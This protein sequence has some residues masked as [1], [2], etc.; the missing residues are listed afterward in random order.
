MKRTI[1]LVFIGC[2]TINNLLAQIVVDNNDQPTILQ[3]FVDM[4]THPRNDLAFGSELFYGCP[5][6][7]ISQAM[8]NCNGY[9]GGYGMFDNTQGNLFRNK[10]VEEGEGSF[11][12]HVEHIREGY[13]NFG[14]WPSF[15]SIFHQQMWIDWIRRAHEGGL[16]IMVAL[17]THSHCMA[18][19]AETKGPYDDKTV[20]DNSI[21]GIRDLVKN[22]DFMEIALS[23][24]DVRRIVHSGKL[25]VILGVEMD[26]IGNFYQPVETKKSAIIY[27]PNPG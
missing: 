17:A 9:H 20:M 25:A 3:G 6:G 21:E 10:L 16:N 24:Q 1:L 18:D 14:Y 12:G 19:A 15:C 4:H 11:C 27:H 13:P 7:D 8:G 26:N 23:S 22:S 5:Y 2:C